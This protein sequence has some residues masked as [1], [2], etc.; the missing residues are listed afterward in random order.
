MSRGEEIKRDPEKR[1]KK[2]RKVFRPKYA[3]RPKH[4]EIQRNTPKHPEIL[5]EVE[6]GVSRTGLYTGTRFSVCSSQNGTEYTTMIETHIPQI[7]LKQVLT[8]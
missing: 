1:E 5:P 2:P 3:Y 6:W 4:T 7:E 8:Y